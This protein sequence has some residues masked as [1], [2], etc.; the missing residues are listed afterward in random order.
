[1]TFLKLAFMAHEWVTS[2]RDTIGV[3]LRGQY[4]GICV[5]LLHVTIWYALQAMISI[6]INSKGAWGA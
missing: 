6:L 3:L 1:M 5:E 2:G 4:N